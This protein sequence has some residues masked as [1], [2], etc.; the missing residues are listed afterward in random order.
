[1]HAILQMLS[2]IRLCACHLI[3]GMLLP[4]QGSFYDQNSQACQDMRGSARNFTLDSHKRRADE[5]SWRNMEQMG[6]R[7]TLTGYIQRKH[8]RGV[9]HRPLTLFAAYF[10]VYVYA[11]VW[12]VA[13]DNNMLSSHA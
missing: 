1:M 13:Y 4:G 9:T 11:R 2:Q 8:Q 3:P 6:A 7:G 12:N 10:Y 5:C